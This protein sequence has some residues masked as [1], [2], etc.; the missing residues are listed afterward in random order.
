MR[1]ALS[2]QAIVPLGRRKWSGSCERK[3]PDSQGLGVSGTLFD[4]YRASSAG[5]CHS[6]ERVF[7]RLCW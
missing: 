1:D 4:A 2:V 3:D 7:Q 6:T 5:A